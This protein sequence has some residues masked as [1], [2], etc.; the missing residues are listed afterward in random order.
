MNTKIVIGTIVLVLIVVGVITFVSKDNR[1]AL[2][3]NVVIT[4]YSDDSLVVEAIFN[5]TDETVTFSHPETGEVTLPRVVSASGARY[6]NE[7]ESLV[8]WEHQGEL[9]ITKDGEMVFQGATQRDGGS[10]DDGIINT[11]TWTQTV[12]G[13]NPQTAGYIIDGQPVKLEDGVAEVAGVPD[14]ASKT[15]TRYFGNDFVTDLN[16]DGRDDVVFILTQGTG[17]SGTFYYVVAALN[18]VNGYVGS[19][20]YLLGDRISPQTIE[21]SPNPQH[22]NVIV[23]NYAD[24]AA[25]EPMTIEPS[26]G[27][28]AYLK[29]DT[30]Y[31]QWGVVE[32]DFEGE[33]NL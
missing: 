20:G 1:T 26:V 8:F 21:K 23:V 32:P 4:S 24:R 9:T 12:V 15:I 31:M 14:S 25:G 16:D 22:Q 3:E 5:N 2:P 28:S 19:D 29:L 17:G 10:T 7:D 30:E 27:R 18:T 33:S 6:A 13:Q 11:H